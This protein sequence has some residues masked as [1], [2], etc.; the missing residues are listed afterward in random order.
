MGPFLK[1]SP[2]ISGAPS[3]VL[4]RAS[5]SGPVS[6]ATLVGGGGG[7]G[8]STRVE[9]GQRAFEWIPPTNAGL[10]AFLDREP[11]TRT[12]TLALGEDQSPLCQPDTWLRHV[13]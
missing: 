6:E 1:Q 11:P 13:I 10:P 9:G 8:P 5:S 2:S 3:L 4:A 7:N 12:R